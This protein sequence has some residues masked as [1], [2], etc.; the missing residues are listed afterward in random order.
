MNIFELKKAKKCYSKKKKRKKKM[1]IVFD[2]IL[3]DSN[4]EKHR[5]Q[6]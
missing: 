1:N 2:K 3:F 5:T 6:K 4:G